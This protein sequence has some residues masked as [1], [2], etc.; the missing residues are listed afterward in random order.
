MKE[1]ILKKLDEIEKQENAR[2]LVAVES[3]SRAWGF[4]SP[5]SDYDVRFIYIRDKEEYLRLDRTR[6][7]IEY[8]VTGDLD[9]NGWDIQKALKL[10]Y[11]SN[12]TLFEWFS[13]PIVYRETEFAWELRKIIMRYFS[14]RK[15]LHHYLSMA[16][17]NCREFLKGEMVKAKKYFYVL[18]PILACLW[19]MDYRIAPPMLFEEL[20]REEMDSSV[21]PEVTD[22]LRI[23]REEP[24]TVLIPRVDKVNE[25]IERNLL[26]VK[27]MISKL[28]DEVHPEWKE[29]NT[30]FLNILGTYQSL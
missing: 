15:G 25:Y 9:I 19:I 22:L 13:S 14:T 28:P 8:P 24:E 16:E 6:D 12:P 2:I 26:A 27:E 10:L 29:L 4:S 30:I 3:G 23:K 18:R 11:S 7:V 17:R 5:D 1:L 21:I 20:M